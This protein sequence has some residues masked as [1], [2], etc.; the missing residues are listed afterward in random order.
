MID[1]A[2]TLSSGQT[3][4]F[5]PHGAGYLGVVDTRAAFVS[6][7]DG[8]LSLRCAR[9]DESFWHRYFDLDREYAQ[10]LAPHLTHPYLAACARAYPGLKLLRQPV[11]EALCAFILSA[12]NHQK[13]I[14]SLYLGISQRLGE[15][16]SFGG[17][18]LHAF[19]SP[20]KLAAAPE[21]LLREIGAGYRAAYLKRSA[22]M[23]AGGFS[24]DIGSMGYEQALRHL[25]SLPGVGEKVADC[26]LLFASDHGCA[27][28]VDVWMERVMRERY[29]LTGTRPAVKRG[30]QAIFGARAGLAQQFLFHGARSGLEI[31][32]GGEGVEP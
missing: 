24:L 10:M 20:D 14:Q 18:K 23:V 7:R 15:P 32:D 22:E 31:A 8:E 5:V 3:F 28:P 1:L 21:A 4:A 13:R 25:C 2:H 6:E 26:V 30:A 27:F 17:K 9:G 29:G 11:W 16:V 19:P 12:N